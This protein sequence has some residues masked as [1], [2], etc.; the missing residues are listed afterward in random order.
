MS[1][2]ESETEQNDTIEA[3][4]QPT[5]DPTDE[6]HRGQPTGEPELPLSEV[7]GLLKNERRR[8]VLKFLKETEEPATTSDLAEYVA[9]QETEK[10][11]VEVTSSERKRAYVGLYQ[12]H[13]PKMDAMDVIEF[14]KPR[15]IVELGANADTVDPY[16]DSAADRGD[17]ADAPWPLRFLGLSLVSLVLLGIGS[18]ADGLVLYGAF[19]TVVVAFG[20]LSLLYWNA[21][22]TAGRADPSVD[23]S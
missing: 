18:M 3:Q 5:G 9:S 10:P 23:G 14:N 4:R 20:A 15:G 8:I 12:C 19:A 2:S 17:T 16:L 11:I 6:P 1:Q 21:T 22:R 13:L 7:F